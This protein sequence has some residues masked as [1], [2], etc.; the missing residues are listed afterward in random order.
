[1]E[2]VKDIKMEMRPKIRYWL[3]CAAVDDTY[4]VWVNDK[5]A[6]FP[7]QVMKEVEVTN[8]LEE[9]ENALRVV[10]N[11]NLYN[12]LLEEGMIWKGNSIPFTEKR[13][14][15]CETEEKPVCL[16]KVKSNSK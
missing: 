9:G 10:V 3:P 16:Y 11:S 6:D 7:D 5:K 8:L 15:I 4:Q 2:F 12:R 14:G 1:M 13:Y